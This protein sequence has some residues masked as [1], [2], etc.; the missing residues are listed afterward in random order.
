MSLAASLLV[1]LAASL[2]LSALWR[3]LGRGDAATGGEAHRKHQRQAVPAIGGLAIACAWSA[4]FLVARGLGGEE[5]EAARASLA[6]TLPVLPVPSGAAA[7]WCAAGALV[8]ALLV[9]WVDDERA[10][11]LPPAAKLGGAAACG[12]LLALP[13]L[14]ALPPGAALG[15]TAAYALTAILACSALNTFDNAD[16]A[17]AGLS[18]AG[19]WVAGSPLAAG[20]LGVWLLNLFARRRAAEGD[21]GA[22]DPILYLGDAGSHLLGVAALVVPGAWPLLWVPLLDLARVSIVRLRLGQL[23]WRGDRRHLA[24]RLQRL[25]LSPWAVVAALLAVAAPAL[26]WRTSLGFGLSLGLFWLAVWGTRAVAEEAAPRTE[27]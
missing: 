13:L 6:P 25:G 20:A 14:G 2:A 8:L 18:T 26:A 1:S 15:W 23:P 4:L 21:P 3:R 24:H 7:A 19:L 27:V 16:G 22:G 12:V 5:W 17:A 11:G 10:G 9:G